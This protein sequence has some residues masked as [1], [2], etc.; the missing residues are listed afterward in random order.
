MA[1]DLQSQNLHPLADIL[2]AEELPVPALLTDAF[3]SSFLEGCYFTD[4]VSFS[5]DGTFVVEARLAF[6]HSIALE[7]PGGLF[8]LS[9]GGGSPAEWTCCESRFVIGAEPLI[10]LESIIVSLE[11]SRQLLIPMRDAATEDDSAA[12]TVLSLGELDLWIDAGGIHSSFQGAVELPL[13]KIAG[14]D[15]IISAKGVSFLVEADG[16]M[17]VVEEATLILPSDL[18]LPPGI[19][20]GVSGARIGSS[21]FTGSLSLDLDLQLA[22][23]GRSFAYH[24]A[25]DATPPAPATIF[26]LPGGLNHIGVSIESNRF[27]AFD[28]TGSL[29]LPWFDVSVE[30]QIGRSADGAL[31]LALR[32]TGAPL[33]L[34]KV[35]L[36]DLAIT[37]M[38]LV[39]SGDGRSW[40]VSL[41]GRLQLMVMAAQGLVWPALEVQDLRVSSD[42]KVSIG[43]AWME[44]GEP[45]VLDLWGFKLEISR[46]GIGT[47]DGRMWMD[48]SG[49]LRLMDQLPAGIGVEGFQI[50]WPMDLSQIPAD[51]PVNFALELSKQIEI[52]FDGVELSFGVPGSVE[53]AGLIRFFKDRQTVGF[54]GD[55]SLKVPAAGFSAEAGLLIGY[56]Q[57]SPPFPFLYLQFGLNLPAG[58]PLA[59]SGLALK[60]AQGMFGL[61]VVPD[62][63]PEQNWYHDWY[64]RGPIVGA[65]PANKWKPG[66]DALA[67]GI[68]VTIT[69]A[70]G[71]LKSTRGLLVLS[72]P[73][74]VLMIEGRAMLL[75]GLAPS[76]EPPLRALAVFDGN[77]GT[78]QFNVEAEAELVQ[79]VV[80]AYAMM[81]AFFDFND[82]TRWHLYLGQDTPADRRIRANI[83]KFDGAFLFKADAYF[84]LDMVGAQTLRSRMGVFVGFKPNIP[85]IGPVTI[86][87]DAS[88]EGKAE[89]T[90][91]PEQFTGEIDLNAAVGISVCGVGIQLGAHAGVDTDGPLP[92]HVAAELEV[93]A[94]MPWPLEPVEAE[95]KV[96]WTLPLPPEIEPPLTQVSLASRFSSKG[97]SMLAALAEPADGDA[98]AFPIH[99]DEAHDEAK[100]D[101]AENSP[102]VAMDSHVVLD[103]THEMNSAFFALH[104]NG[105]DT[106]KFHAGAFAFIP[107]LKRVTIYS[108]ERSAADARITWKP[109]AVADENTQ[110]LPGVWTAGSEP[111]RPDS[112]SAR[113]LQLWTDNPLLH[114]HPALTPVQE[115]FLGAVPAG[116]P[117]AERLL[118]DYPDLMRPLP[119][120]PRRTCVTFSQWAGQSLLP[121]QPALVTHGAR[122]SCQD[123]RISIR[124]ETEPAHDTLLTRLPFSRLGDL[125]KLLLK[126]KEH[127][128]MM[129]GDLSLRQWKQW[130]HQQ[131][132][133]GRDALIKR[134]PAFMDA[135][136]ALF[137]RPRTCHYLHFTDN[138]HLH[139]PEPVS[140]VVLHFCQ[141]VDSPPTGKGSR[142]AL[143]L[144]AAPTSLAELWSLLRA[145][146]NWSALNEWRAI[147]RV[148]RDTRG[149]DVSKTEIQSLIQR[150][151]GLLKRHGDGLDCAVELPAAITGDEDE[152]RIQSQT[153]KPFT[154]L[155]L[156]GFKGMSLCKV[157]W[158]SA[159]DATRTQRS[160]EQAAQ[161]DA[162]PPADLEHVFRGHLFYRAVIETEVE[163]TLNPP[164]GLEELYDAVFSA[165]MQTLGLDNDKQAFTQSVY[166]QTKEP[167]SNLRPYVLK[168]LPESSRHPHFTA[169]EIELRFLR[170]HVAA[171]FGVST[172]NPGSLKLVARDPA[173]TLHEAACSWHKAAD[174]TLFPEEQS[175]LDHRPASG[176][177]SS[178][179]DVLR[180]D[181][182]SRQPLRPETRYD[183]LLVAADDLLLLAGNV[184]ELAPDALVFF[185]SRMVTSA[186]SSFADM[187]SSAAQAWPAIEFEPSTPFNINAF[188]SVARRYARK[189]LAFQKT[190]SLHRLDLLYGG[191]HA[192]ETKRLSLR[193]ARAAAEA[194]FHSVASSL[195]M[196]RLYEKPPGQLDMALLIAMPGQHCAGIWIRSAES[197]DLQSA[198]ARIDGQ[199]VGKTTWSLCRSGSTAPLPMDAFHDTCSRHLILLL[200]DEVLGAGDYVVT[201]SREDMGTIAFPFNT[202]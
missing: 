114:T 81:E 95:V 73:G 105:E 82:L 145:S 180:A 33:D 125:Q 162:Q 85:P 76:A 26:G 102:V 171:M 96:E 98:A 186:F 51:D 25:D 7:I 106:K 132:T 23:D 121:G 41:S 34:H 133:G 99:R 116:P 134:H 149:K 130:A 187:A 120:E 124:S 201:L 167:P 127:A 91:R 18:G 123:G 88:L 138:L 200:P 63:E 94:D 4:L 3:R 56:N 1:H 183:L 8:A 113:R 35:G 159:A 77:E 185:Q 9:I 169:Q 176:T 172:L 48:L 46:A 90:V 112:P 117:L 143:R 184:L 47:D 59:Q 93:H 150:V 11:I 61:N 193:D 54:S 160:Q 173:G 66:R 67:L 43:G 92:F 64:K 166:F 12:A 198:T 78:V 28:L 10:A 42:G 109:L 151:L 158:I 97:V 71:Y 52:K 16:T 58:I 75:D 118:A 122:F 202:V 126:D 32:N 155:S 53:F 196:Q 17:L 20:M 140:E 80:E 179:D 45:A 142:G 199:T 146:R 168:V 13:S 181:F 2:A 139:F 188:H 86:T 29:L 74:P 115:L 165:L 60:A 119:D 6:D 189:R 156:A 19:T 72:F 36:L 157:C 22:A 153:G 31:S 100:D 107:R 14:T 70:D 154:C 136:Q 170:T 50:S 137:P 135:W 24:D 161:N 178:G 190:E 38:S 15:I 174:A 79:D 65:H 57:E 89:V 39:R 30:I 5:S 68:G 164:V 44:L 148:L 182:H 191:R 83:L 131:K 152:W 192:L 195:S 144:H 175:W 103:F 40:A 147:V 101:R 197:L 141:P 69:T 163:R 87:L 49:S 129:R 84:M 108:G 62:K 177:A 104:P 128:T 37:S 21:G 194:E 27:L 110:T 55:M 111:G